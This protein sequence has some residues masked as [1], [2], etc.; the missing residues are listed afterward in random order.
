MVLYFTHLSY[1]SGHCLNTEGG[2]ETAGKSSISRQK[3]L[4]ISNLFKHVTVT[5]RTQK[6]KQQKWENSQSK[7][8][9]ELFF[10]E[11]C[12]IFCE[13]LMQA[14][15]CIKRKFQPKPC[16][17]YSVLWILYF[18]W[19]VLCILS[20]YFIS[21][22]WILF[23]ITSMQ[24]ILVTCWIKIPKLFLELILWFAPIWANYYTWF[25]IQQDHGH[26]S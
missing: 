4:I 22:S 17:F 19:S 25:A 3:A 2:K 12:Q 5:D 9:Q 13:F 26:H 23:T 7:L 21:F 15:Q 1:F 18:A 24:A 10:S 20:N 11:L 14:N 8:N 16:T 6:C